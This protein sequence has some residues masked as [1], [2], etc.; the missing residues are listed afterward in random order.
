M[1]ISTKDQWHCFLQTVKKG[2]QSNTCNMLRITDQ[3]FLLFKTYQG[4]NKEKLNKNSGG[5]LGFYALDSITN[6]TA[7]ISKIKTTSKNNGNVLFCWIILCAV[8]HILHDS[9]HERSALNC[10]FFCEIALIKKE[11]G[12]KLCNRT[13][14]L[15]IISELKL[16]KQLRRDAL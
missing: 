10:T 13:I 15:K 12:I 4:T 11:L 9:C 3:M 8:L 6:A 5:N 7:A 2:D 14:S 1:P 16:I